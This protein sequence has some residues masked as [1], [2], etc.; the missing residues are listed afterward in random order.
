[1]VNINKFDRETLKPT[2]T[3][4]KMTLPTAEDIKAEAK[5]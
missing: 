5:Q 4:E 1:M 3:V 2:E